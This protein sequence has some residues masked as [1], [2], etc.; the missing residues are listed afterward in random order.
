MGKLTIERAGWGWLAS[1]ENP[2]W[3]Q[4]TD[5]INEIM[6]ADRSWVLKRLNERSVELEFLQRG[7]NPLADLVEDTVVATDAKGLLEAQLKLRAEISS[8]KETVKSKS[9]QAMGFINR[10]TRSEVLASE[11]LAENGVFGNDL[12]INLLEGRM[13]YAVLRIA[14][15]IAVY[16]AE[17][18]N[19][20]PEDLASIR[21]FSAEE[22]RFFEAFDISVEYEKS[23][24][25][26]YLLKAFSKGGEE[27]R[28][29]EWA[30][31]LDEGYGG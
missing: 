1:V 10:V 13:R 3:R 16:R 26:A 25:G 19:A 28:E 9:L 17:H 31:G 24:E 15:G 5:E 29:Y 6:G 12:A 18:G 20:L 4:Q 2:T 11:I 8:H 14:A 30:V 22:F 23:G 7:I 27:L 21:A